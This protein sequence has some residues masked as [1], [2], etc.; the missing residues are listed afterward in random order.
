MSNQRPDGGFRSQLTG[1]VFNSRAEQIADDQNEMNLRNAKHSRTAQDALN[2]LTPEEVRA[3][4]EDSERQSAKRRNESLA[5]FLSAHSDV[6]VDTPTNAAKLTA[7]LVA[8]GKAESFTY[9]DLEEAMLVLGNAGQLELNPDGIAAREQE[10]AANP[11]PTEEDMYAMDLDTLRAKANQQAADEA[12]MRRNPATRADY[13]GSEFQ[14]PFTG[15]SHAVKGG[16][17]W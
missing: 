5:L 6:Y 9:D 16:R 11:Q 2:K 15:N 13:D 7:Y 8:K 17:R 3:I 14:N 1:K 4:G 10:A 12:A